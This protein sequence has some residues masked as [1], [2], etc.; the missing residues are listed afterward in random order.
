M[1]VYNF[2]Q[3]FDL[4]DLVILDLHGLLR[5]TRP[6]E[7]L[8]HLPLLPLVLVVVAVRH[9][10]TVEC[11]GGRAVPDEATLVILSDTSHWR[12]LLV[13]L[14]RVSRQNVNLADAAI[15]AS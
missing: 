9:L 10:E 4:H 5:V 1:L 11:G 6:A 14:D 12:L 13:N 2:G 7:S 8:V 3:S 15:S